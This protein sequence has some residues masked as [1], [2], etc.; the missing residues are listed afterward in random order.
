LKKE[1]DVL[2]AHPRETTIWHSTDHAHEIDHTYNSTENQDSLTTEERRHSGQH[3]EIGLDIHPVV[4]NHVTI[5]VIEEVN[6]RRIYNNWDVNYSSLWHSILHG[7]P[8]P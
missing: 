4:G 8:H 3:S 5:Q 6:R 1:D 7:S 2:I